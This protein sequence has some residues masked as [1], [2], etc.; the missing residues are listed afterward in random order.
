MSESGAPVQT[1]P[2]RGPSSPYA[3]G[4]GGTVLEHRY[5]AM[6]LSHLITGDP[7]P[8]LGNDATVVR[9]AFQ[10][11]TQSPVDD[12]LVLGRGADGADRRAS[13]AVRRRP[14]FVPSDNQS[15][16]L[17]ASYLQI[18]THH[19]CDVRAGRWRLA[20]ASA[21]STRVQQV[22]E[23]A[24]IARAAPD[25]HTFREAVALERRTTRSVRKRL[26]SLDQVVE[27]ATQR[28]DAGEIAP[29]E[30]T[31]RLL[32]SL[33]VRVLRL[34]TPDESDRATLVAQLRPATVNGTVAEADRLLA[35]ITQLA[36]DYAPTAAEV[37][38]A[39]L[40]RD[41]VGAANLRRSSRH[42]AAWRK[43][44]GLSDRL[45]QRTCSYLGTL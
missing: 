41:L 45:G 19:W 27:A 26:A 5:G 16:D 39:M 22:S 24:S 40:R 29:P 23:L 20:L 28:I 36:S 6:L 11:S 31:W 37:T 33:T 13:V 35:A 7:L 43:L 44:D 2:T 21:P 34:E 8:E 42:D 14:R 3:T 18:V 10:A 25:E 17:L 4:G 32:S 30:L 1:S 9:V 15:V 38:E 12:L